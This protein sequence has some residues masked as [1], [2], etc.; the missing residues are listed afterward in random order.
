MGS[1]VGIYKKTEEKQAKRIRKASRTLSG[2][3]SIV[4]EDV[5]PLNP[6][7][8]SINRSL[9]WR[10]F[11]NLSKNLEQQSRI[12][13]CSD[14]SYMGT[15]KCWGSYNAP[16]LH[17]IPPAMSI[18]SIGNPKCLTLFLRLFFLFLLSA[19]DSLSVRQI[20]NPAPTSLSVLNVLD[21]LWTR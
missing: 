14:L 18:C 13:F 2:V 15:A 4:L 3:H 20:H 9:R 12:S 1:L 6:R 19:L 17:L 16:F 21:H 8:L 7:F 5:E 10:G 11:D